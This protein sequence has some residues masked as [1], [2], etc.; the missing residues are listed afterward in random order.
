MLR[1]QRGGE[2]A[3]ERACGL[4]SVRD[5]IPWVLEPLRG[6]FLELGGDDRGLRESKRP[7]GA[8]QTM[9]VAAQLF[10]SRRVVVRG[11][12][13]FGQLCD[14]PQLITGSLQVLVPYSGR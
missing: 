12:Q 3:H 4:A 14:R 7:G 5:P 8:V 9:G 2:P 1:E 13:P 11:D 6:G 10:N